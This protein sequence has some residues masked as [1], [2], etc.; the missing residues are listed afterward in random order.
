MSEANEQAANAAKENSEAQARAAENVSEA[1]KAEASKHIAE[2]GE[3]ATAAAAA[4]QALAETT[5]AETVKENEENVEWLRQHATKTENSLAELAQNQGR[6]MESLPG[7]LET[8]RQ[9]T[10][11]GV[12]ELLTPPKLTEEPKVG[13]VNPLK[14]SESQDGRKGKSGED[15]KKKTGPKY[16]AN[17]I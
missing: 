11:A 16:R 5:A 8:H 15:K 17:W 9:Q 4:A 7:I 2:A 1:A 10:I 12:K 13:E 14:E 6:L 3:A